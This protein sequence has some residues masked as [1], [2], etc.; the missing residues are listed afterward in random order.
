MYTQKSVSEIDNPQG[1]SPYF[2]PF[3]KALKF[4]LGNCRLRLQ[5]ESVGH[6]EVLP[7]CGHSL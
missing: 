1:L 2:L 4:V 5:V 3:T 6:E 7:P